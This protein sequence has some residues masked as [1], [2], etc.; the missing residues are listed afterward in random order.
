MFFMRLF[1]FV[2]SR[3]GKVGKKKTWSV[4]WSIKQKKKRKKTGSRGG[5]R[6]GEGEGESEKKKE[7]G[8]R[9]S[10]QIFTHQY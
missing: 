4:D 2:C 5:G 10:S 7:V 1:L 6:G 3:G 8:V 9:Y